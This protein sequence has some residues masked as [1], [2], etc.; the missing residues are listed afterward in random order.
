MQ[1]PHHGS[2]SNVKPNFENKYPAKYYFVNDKDTN[3]IQKNA[4]LYQSLAQNKKLL[5]SRALCPDI[6][7]CTTVIK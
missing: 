7:I 4:T 3:R 1:I 5:V 2:K 6:I